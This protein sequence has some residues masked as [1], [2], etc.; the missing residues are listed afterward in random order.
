MRRDTYERALRSAAQISFLSL[1]MVACGGPS[2]TPVQD[3]SAP[4]GDT[5]GDGDG[6]KL[7]AAECDKAL[8]DAYPNGD[9]N[10]FNSSMPTK[11][12][13]TGVPVA[14]LVQCCNDIIAAGASDITLT[15][16]DTGCCSL[17]NET[18]AV[19]GVGVACTPW[20]PPM[21]RAMRR[22]ASRAVMLS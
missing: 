6:E 14:T 4:G 18:Q 16:R 13:E 12:A 15:L 5:P 7:G 22:R 1:P 3:A 10:W 9:P 8:K 20:G 19:E 2:Y 21:P 11:R 17:N